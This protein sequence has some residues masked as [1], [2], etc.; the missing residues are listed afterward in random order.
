MKLQNYDEILDTTET[1]VGEYET[2]FRHRFYE[3]HV[4]NNPKFCF[5]KEKLGVTDFEDYQLVQTFSESDWKNSGV[6]VLHKKRFQELCKNEQKLLKQSFKQLSIDNTF[7]INYDRLSEKAKKALHFCSF[8]PN[9]MI[10][11]SLLYSEDAFNEKVWQE[12]EDSSLLSPVLNNTTSN[13]YYTCNKL[14]QNFIRKSNNDIVVNNVLLDLI[15]LIIEKYKNISKE[16]LHKDHNLANNIFLQFKSIYEHLKKEDNEIDL[17]VKLEFIEKTVTH[18]WKYLHQASTAKNFLSSELMKQLLD[19]IDTQEDNA[20]IATSLNNIGLVYRNKG[21]FDEALV[22]YQKALKIRCRLYDVDESQVEAEG[23]AVIAQSLNNIGTVYYNK[24]EFDEALVYYLKALKIRCRIFD[25]D[26]SQVETQGNAAIAQSLNNIGSV[27]Y[28][29]GD[30]NEALTYY[31]KAFKI[32]C[33]VFG[34]DETQ[35]KTQGNAAIATSLNNIGNVYDNKGNIDEALM[36]YHNAL[37]I[38]C[39]VFGVD[40]SQIESQGNS[41]IAQLLNNIGL[42]YNLKGD[43]DEALLYYHKSLNIS[44]RVFGVDESLVE[45]QGNSDIAELL[46]NIGNVYYNKGEIDEALTYYQKTLKILCRVFTNNINHPFI[47]DTKQ[48]IDICANVQ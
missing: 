45:I 36:Y 23:N 48:S 19:D 42:V 43:Y 47:K 28:Y 25:V 35:V 7:K 11:Q 13:S 8:L 16:I 41:D 24:S 12:L 27:Y 39:R 44:F 34:V 26:E 14:V 4:R 33:R 31:Q 18:S 30:N 10:M 29:N 32:R 21:E 3:E 1:N 2:K 17:Q 15:K 6:S 40:E 46:Y 37:T 22:Y 38:R 20:D 5:L 9:E